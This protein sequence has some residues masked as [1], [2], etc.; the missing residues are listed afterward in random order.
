MSLRIRAYLSDDREAVVALALRAWEPVF[1]SMEQALGSR[2]FAILRG[3]WRQTQAADVVQTV[4]SD[5]NRTWVAETAGAPAGF[6][7]ATAHPA[8]A[9]GEIVMLAV[10][11][12]HQR[13]GVAAALTDTAVDWL[14]RQGMTVAMVETGGDPGHLPARRTYE[15]AGFTALPVTRFF[16]IL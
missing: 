3:D 6:V 14:R 5:A 12:A 9:I 7:V 11:P 16:K 13:A 10:D 8:G 2:L 1:D 4:A 15:S